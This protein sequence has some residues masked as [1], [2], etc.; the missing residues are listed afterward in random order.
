MEKNRKRKYYDIDRFKK[1][2]RY[3]CNGSY[4]ILLKKFE[5]YL[6]D[7]PYDLFT[8]NEYLN[9][10]IKLNQLEKVKPYLENITF[11]KKTKEIDFSFLQILKLNYYSRMHMFEECYTLF[12]KIK[13]DPKIK[14]CNGNA[15][16]I[17]DLDF[18]LRFKLGLL[19]TYEYKTNRYLFQQIINYDIERA[20]NHIQKHIKSVENADGIIIN[21]TH[22]A[23]FLEQIQKE[24]PN[25]NHFNTLYFSNEYCFKSSNLSYTS[26]DYI[27][28]SEVITLDDTNQITT[29]YPSKN[30]DNIPITDI[31][32]PLLEKDS[33]VKRKSQIEKFNERYMKK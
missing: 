27:N 22:L 23:D 15:K 13:D 19:K 3:K 17:S 24:L 11:T 8:I 4:D 26:G 20:A 28:L 18:Y 14:L 5:E 33:K 12:R 1:L 21:S 2:I 16:Y 25:E 30:T 7:Y 9:L 31:T 32:S 10:C 6:E 29:M